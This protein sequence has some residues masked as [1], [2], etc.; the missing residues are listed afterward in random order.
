MDLLERVQRRTMQM[1]KVLEHLS[2]ND[3]LKELGLFCLEKGKLQGGLIA[4][5]QYLKG[6]YRKEGESL[7]VQANSDR[8]RSNGFKLKEDRFRLY[9]R[10]KFLT[11]RVVKHWNRLPIEIVDAPS[12]EA[13]KAMLYVVLRKW[14]P[15]L[16]DVSLPMAGGLKPDDL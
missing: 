10:M 6:S 9:A 8:T 5:F 11:V 4:A 3:K 7:F 12:L 2:F 16:L 1:I 14:S 15:G 13:L